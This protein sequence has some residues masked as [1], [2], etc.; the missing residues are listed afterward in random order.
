MFRDFANNG[1]EMTVPEM[2]VTIGG[3]TGT[4]YVVR[5][6]DN[7]TG[8]YMI[9]GALKGGYMTFQ[10]FFA[11]NITPGLQ[12]ILAGLGIL[13]GTAALVSAIP[14]ATSALMVTLMAIAICGGIF[15]GS[16]QVAIGLGEIFGK[17]LEEHELPWWIY[18]PFEHPLSPF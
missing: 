5:N 18:H 15:Y 4:G 14:V 13:I 6:P 7:G 8:A 10:E 17:P 12:R 16:V 9:D 1:K 3:W 11:E 2:N